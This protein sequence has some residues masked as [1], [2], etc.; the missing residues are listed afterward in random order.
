MKALNAA[1]ISSV[2]MKYLIENSKS[3]KFEELHLSLVENEP[4]PEGFSVGK[5]ISTSGNLVLL[6]FLKFLLSS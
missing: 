2:F 5:L 3:D 4:V 6:I 1:Y